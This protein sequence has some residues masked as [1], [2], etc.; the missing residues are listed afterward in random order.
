MIQKWHI[1]KHSVK[2]AQFSNT[3]MHGT[4]GRLGYYFEPTLLHFFYN[5]IVYLPLVIV[6]FGA[7][8]YLLPQIAKQG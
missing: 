5:S 1:A 8:L 2:L 6:L 3:G 4:P 7:R